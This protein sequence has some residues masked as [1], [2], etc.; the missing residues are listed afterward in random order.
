M[1][2]A[3]ISLARRGEVSSCRVGS[4]HCS[5]TPHALAVA[6]DTHIS[7]H[8]LELVWPSGNGMGLCTTLELRISTA[9]DGST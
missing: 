9:M 8:A 1:A 6:G 5:P 7:A 4:S 3:N 2:A